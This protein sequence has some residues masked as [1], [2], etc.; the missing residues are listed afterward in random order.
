MLV[1]NENIV[2][3]LHGAESM[4]DYDRRTSDEEAI[5]ALTLNPAEMFGVADRLGSI[6]PGKIANLIVTDGNPLEIRT[7]IRH[8]VIAGQEV[9]TDN[10]HKSLYERYRG[11]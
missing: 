7:R 1:E 6:E 2:C 9:S 5:K 10:R 4:S 8:L 3:A 11:R